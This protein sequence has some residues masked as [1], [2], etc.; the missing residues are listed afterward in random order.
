MSFN[1][2]IKRNSFSNNRNPFNRGTA[3]GSVGVGS[4]ASSG[5]SSSGNRGVSPWESG[6]MPPGRGILPTPTNNLSLNSPQAQLVIASNLLTNLLRTQQDPSPAVPS[7][8]SLGSN[9][10]LGPNFRNQQAFSAPG[11]FTD[12]QVRSNSLKNQRSQPYN[13][14]GNRARDGW[15]GPSSV[16][17][18]RSQSGNQ[19]ANG[20]RNQHRND[21]NSKANTAKQ[22]QTIKKEP[23]DVQ[24]SDKEKPN[25]ETVVTSNDQGDVQDE[26]T[27]VKIENDDEAPMEISQA[28]NTP[29]EE[30]DSSDAPGSADKKKDDGNGKKSEA[31]HAESRYAVVAINQMFCHV[32]NKHMWDGFSF[33]NHLRG[34]AHQIM[35]DKHDESYKLKVDLMRHEL[36]IAEEQREM[37]LNNSKRR[38]KRVAVDLN[39]REY[40]TMCDLNFFGTL[41][42]H[43]K[44]DKHQQ[45]KTFLHPRCGPCVKE[46]H[47]RIEY[48]EHCLTPSHMVAVATEEKK[49]STKIKLPKGESEVRTVEDEEKEVGSVAK[50][51]GKDEEILDETQYITDISENMDMSKVPTF[52]AARHKGLGLGA[53]MVKEVT[54]FHCE[55]CKRFMLT[56][57]DVKAHLKTMIHY[58]HFFSEIKA[59]QAP[60]Q[61][62]E[63][64]EESKDAE[65]KDDDESAATE[66]DEIAAKRPKLEIGD[67]QDQEKSSEEANPLPAE[68]EEVAED[69]DN[70]EGDDKYDPM[71]AEGESEEDKDKAEGNGAEEADNSKKEDNKTADVWEDIDNEDESQV[72]NLIDSDEK[73]ESIPE[74]SSPKNKQPENTTSPAVSTP[75]TTPSTP[76]TPSTPTA[77]QPAIINKTPNNSPAN[78][79]SAGKNRG[80]GFRGGGPRGHQ[81]ARRSR[82]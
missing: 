77:P 8:L 33:E 43:R 71:E 11:R 65:S 15:R 44:S 64:S 76:A 57:E 10:N 35:M 40:C 45:L 82:R 9:L 6:V 81:R 2:G 12:R 37:S 63:K 54:G 36:R 25:T 38:G 49:K 3:S 74:T 28:M 1:R 51:I 58:R 59:L 42:S 60:S 39:V 20:N 41:S 61:S 52:R 29:E 23:E 68:E 46:F 30:K 80:R 17:Q 16:Q 78:T 31:R 34:R 18:S 72:G 66:G 21:K 48:D 67:Q 55:K 53:S 47:S 56:Q 7:L 14:M 24:N 27:H 22:N 26:N 4:V 69:Y 62:E 73:V 13:K 50:V 5:G 75:V 70:E 79:H 32:C 19:R